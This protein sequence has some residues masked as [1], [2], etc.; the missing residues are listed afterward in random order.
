[1]IFYPSIFSDDYEE[2]IKNQLPKCITDNTG[3]LTDKNKPCEFPFRNDGIMH[4]ECVIDKS[5]SDSPWCATKVGKRKNPL[6]GKWGNC[7]KN[8]C[9][10]L[11]FE[12]ASPLFKGMHI[13]FRYGFKYLQIKYKIISYIFANSLLL[14]VGSCP[15]GFIAHKRR[16]YGFFVNRYARTTWS[17]AQKTCRSFNGGDL[18]TIV[19]K[20]ENDFIAKKV[21]EINPDL[22]DKDHYYPWIGLFIQKRRNKGKLR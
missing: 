11:N 20:S 17:D 14:R 4:N 5:R 15:K 16:C 3:S 10:S 9:Q 12:T 13:F 6:R 8:S 2:S 7:E 21:L 19:T 22:K 1:M 18:V